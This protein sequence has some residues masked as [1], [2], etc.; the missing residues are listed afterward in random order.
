[1]A[2]NTVRPTWQSKQ[3]ASPG[4]GAYAPL[5]HIA[6]DCC[7]LSVVTFPLYSR[8]DRLNYSRTLDIEDIAQNRDRSR[9][10]PSSAMNSHRTNSTL[11]G[12][13]ASRGLDLQATTQ[14]HR[15]VLAHRSEAL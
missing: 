9:I 15:M 5:E 14:R 7:P 8:L 2:D 12:H 6:Q 4:E 1:M 3:A 10:V 13:K 11:P